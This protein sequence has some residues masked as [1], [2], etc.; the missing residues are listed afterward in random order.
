MG[1][2]PQC[3]M[4]AG[5]I[6]PGLTTRR[7][8]ILAGCIT[9]LAVM[10][11]VSLGV[12]QLDRMA[13][14]Q[15]RLDSIAHKNAETPIHPFS[16][17]GQWQDVRDV[18]VRFTGI[19]RHSRVLLLDNQI[20]KGR[21]GYDVIVPVLTRG[22]EILVNLGWVAV[23]RSRNE[24][25]VLAVP[26][27]EITIE[28]VL[29]QPGSNLFISETQTRFNSFPVVIQQLDIAELNTRWQSALPDMVVERLRSE[30]ALSEFTT[31]WQP[32]VM[33]PEKHLGYAVQWFGLAIAAIVIFLSVW[34]RR[35]Q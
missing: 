10:A 23:P 30:P 20:I 16:A 7:W 15:H 3:S 9:L 1:K 18:P 27:G 33:S 6:K 2:T 35:S 28:G 22:R 8:P 17:T 12:W 34:F 11:M 24:L 31:H 4:N 25:P 21:P 14:K 5:Y 26:Q 29:S 13:Q 19:V 32:V